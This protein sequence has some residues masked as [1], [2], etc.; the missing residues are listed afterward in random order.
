MS[1]VK[2]GEDLGR[3]LVECVH[4]FIDLFLMVPCLG[5]LYRCEVVGNIENLV[6]VLLE[7]FKT[8]IDSRLRCRGVLCVKKFQEVGDLTQT[9]GSMTFN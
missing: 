3:V 9:S 1:F 4:I 6:G 8:V 2:D 7:F 5:V